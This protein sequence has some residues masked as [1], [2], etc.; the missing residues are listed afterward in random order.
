[1][2]CRMLMLFFSVQWQW[3]VTKN[4]SNS[5]IERKVTSHQAECWIN[6]VFAMA[7]L[8]KP[9]FR[10]FIFKSVWAI[11]LKFSWCYFCSLVAIHSYR[12]EK[13]NMNILP[14]TFFFFFLVRENRCCYDMRVSKLW[15][16]LHFL[17][18]RTEIETTL[19]E[20]MWEKEQLFTL[21]N[22]FR[23]PHRFVASVGNV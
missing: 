13:S 5:E 20:S 22:H 23:S 3:M 19:V 12:M 17:F 8:H 14:K 15:Q 6:I 11:V 10:S 4:W 1:M 7:L 21:V 2:L 18:L 16:N 9:P